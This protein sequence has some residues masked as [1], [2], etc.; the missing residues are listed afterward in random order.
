MDSFQEGQPFSER[1]AVSIIIKHWSEDKYLGLKS[2]NVH[3]AIFP[4]GGLEKGERPEEAANREIKEET[5]YVN[6]KL[7]KKIGRSHAKFYHV[8]KKENVF[9]HFTSFYFELKNGEQNKI[10]EEENKKHN[11]M[12]LSH[13]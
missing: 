4:T 2:K 9:A 10:T 8:Q 1:E 13:R 7:V 6:F 11:I 3:W 12:L 5:G